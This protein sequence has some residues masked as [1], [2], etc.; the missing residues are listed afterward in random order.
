MRP[1]ILTKLELLCARFF[2]FIACFVHRDIRFSSFLTSFLHILISTE[3]YYIHVKNIEQK[4]TKRF[5]VK[6]QNFRQIFYSYFFSPNC[7]SGRD[8]NTDMFAAD[9]VTHCW[10]TKQVLP[11]FCDSNILLILLFVF[12]A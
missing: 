5:L 3:L 9:A 12:H 6:I 2:S 7:C 10:I 11:G 8:V 4:V 1:I